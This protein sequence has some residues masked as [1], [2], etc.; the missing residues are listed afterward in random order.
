MSDKLDFFQQQK[1][2]NLVSK[3]RL[4]LQSLEDQIPTLTNRDKATILAFLAEMDSAQ[5]LFDQLSASG[6]H[7]LIAERPRFDT[8]K[9]KMRRLAP[10]IYSKLGHSAGLRAVRPATV[11]A[12]THPWWFVDVTVAG[13]REQKNKRILTIGGTLLAILVVFW[14]LFSTV[15][16]PDPNVVLRAELTQ[17]ALDLI[18]TEQ[19]YEAA[20]VNVNQVLE[21]LPEDP[22]TVIMKCVILEQLGRTDE[23]QPCFGLAENLL[24]EPGRFALER[25]RLLWQ[26]GKIDQAQ[27]FVDQALEIDPEFAEAWF[28]AGQLFMARGETNLAYEA[29]NKSADLAL[30]QDNPTLY[31]IAKVNL[32][33]LMQSS[34]SFPDPVEGTQTAE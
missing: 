2:G 21:V 34:G 8:L 13:L 31:T 11:S 10:K 7:D 22:G 33:Q 26:F 3:L 27:V 16:K 24:P 19:D 6:G 15:L 4:H 29:L 23:A 30:A 18:S 12:E 5:A 9:Q 25:G 28:L 17:K 14:I 20:L 1:S 32:G